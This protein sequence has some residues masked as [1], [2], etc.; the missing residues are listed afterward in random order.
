MGK[1]VIV[2]TE[3]DWGFGGK[4]E[5]KGSIY[6]IAQAYPHSLPLGTLDL[7]QGGSPQ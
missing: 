1:H 3:W 6:T 5:K 2:L 7:Q 4:I